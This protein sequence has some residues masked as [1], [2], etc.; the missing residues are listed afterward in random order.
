MWHWMR[1]MWYLVKSSLSDVPAAIRL[2]R[3]VLRN[4]HENLFWAFIYNVIGIPI[5]GRSVV[6]LVWVEIKSDVR[7]GSHEPVQLLRS[8]KCTA[9]ELC[10]SLQYQRDSNKN[11]KKNQ[12]QS[13]LQ[14]V[15]NTD[16]MSEKQE[17][18]TWKK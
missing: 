7:S 16:V 13:E 1:Q 11:N 9:S 4:I 3:A 5:A 8:D 10:K 18:D 6:S 17:E 14:I 2:S 12:Q 15:V